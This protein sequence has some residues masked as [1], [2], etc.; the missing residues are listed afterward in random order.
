MLHSNSRSFVCVMKESW[1]STLSFCLSQLA[2]RAECWVWR[3]GRTTTG[4]LCWTTS[5]GGHRGVCDEG[6]SG[7]TT[8]S[9]TTLTSARLP[10]SSLVRDSMRSVSGLKVVPHRAIC[11]QS[12]RLSSPSQQY[13]TWSYVL[14]LWELDSVTPAHTS[15]GLCLLQVA[16]DLI[17]PH[18]VLPA[19]IPHLH[20]GAVCAVYLAKCVS[21]LFHCLHM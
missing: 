19:V 2:L 1:H 16:L 21:P 11:K 6:R 14:T 8:S 9:F 4:E 3:S 13:S 18:L 5:A 15:D 12:L 17:N 7:P 20:H 10:R